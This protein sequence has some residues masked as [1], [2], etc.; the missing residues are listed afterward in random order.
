MKLLHLLAGWHVCHATPCHAMPPAS[1]HRPSALEPKQCF[2]GVRGEGDAPHRHGQHASVCP[3]DRVRCKQA[4]FAIIIVPSDSARHVD[5]HRCPAAAGGQRAG[6]RRPRR[7]SLYVSHGRTAGLAGR[8]RGRLPRGRRR[9]SAPQTP[10]ASAAVV[11]ASTSGRDEP[12]GSCV[13]SGGR[14][15]RSARRR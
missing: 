1:E 9:T 2:P 5:K 4:V 10:R 11:A 15:G 8:S 6:R 14:G 13:P 7:A 12:P 3:L